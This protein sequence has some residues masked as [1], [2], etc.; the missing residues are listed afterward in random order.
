MNILI[1]INCLLEGKCAVNKD[2]VH[3]RQSFHRRDASSTSVQ[4]N[5]AYVAHLFKLCFSV[6]GVS[7]SFLSP[8]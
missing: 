8:F 6:V 5:G 7:V 3:A 1:Q 4:K 2:H